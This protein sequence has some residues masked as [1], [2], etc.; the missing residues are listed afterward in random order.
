LPDRVTLDG[1]IGLHTIEALQLELRRLARACRLE[2]RQFRVE[3]VGRKR[4]GVGR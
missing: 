1:D 3:T 2:I 4:S